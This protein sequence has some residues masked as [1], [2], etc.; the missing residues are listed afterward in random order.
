MTQEPTTGNFDKFEEYKLFIEDTGRFSDRRQAVSNFIVA[1]NG[2]LVAG[3]ALL[4]TKAGQKASWLSFVALSL[5]AAGIVVC[6]IWLLLIVRYKQAIEERIEQLKKIEESP[7][8]RGCQ[9]MYHTIGK[10]LSFSCIEAGLPCV[11][12]VL[13][14]AF[15]VAGAYLLGHSQCAS[16]PWVGG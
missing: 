8:M 14:I 3:V 16:H 7:G 2:F 6:A 9:R 10:G 4:I 11:F 1:L 12:I 15:I 13:Y 5:L